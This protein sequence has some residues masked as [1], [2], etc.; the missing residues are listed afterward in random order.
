MILYFKNPG[1]FLSV[2]IGRSGNFFLVGVVTRTYDF[3]IHAAV[4]IKYGGI[5]IGNDIHYDIAAAVSV[6]GNVF[7]FFCDNFFERKNFNAF[8][9]S[10]FDEVYIEVMRFDTL[11]IF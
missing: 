4:V 6:S 5:F 9:G 7:D 10:P 8:Y 1:D 3:H 11:F 2:E